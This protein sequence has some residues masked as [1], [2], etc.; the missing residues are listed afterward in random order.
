MRRRAAQGFTLIELVLALSIVAIMVTMLF[1]GLRVGLRAWQRG[2]ERAAELQHSRSMTQLL[3]QSLAGTY[4]YLGRIDQIQGS[5]VLLFKGEAERLNF[6]TV[7]PP[8]PL[9][10]PIPFVAVTLSVDAGTA[11]GLAIR[12]KALPNF[13]PFEAVAPSVV[14]PTIASIRFRYLRIGA[15]WEEAWDSAEERALPTAV[16][17]T[18]TPAADGRGAQPQPIIITVPIRVSAL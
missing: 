7:S 12:E 14:D 3:E 16:E 4:W 5:P 2:E 17:V 18:V 6:V 8:L 15:G 13:D 9:P 11:P 10:A 1:G